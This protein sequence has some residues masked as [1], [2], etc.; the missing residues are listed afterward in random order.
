MS[1]PELK[2]PHV[3]YP[4]SDGK[5]M[6]ES[7]LHRDLLTELVDSVNRHF[8]AEPD[9]Y[10]SGNLL[11]YFEEGNPQMSVAPDFFLVRGVPK[12]RRRIYRLWEEGKGPDVVV[13][14]T[15]R[16]THLEDIGHKR[17]I[18]EEL[19]VEEYFLFD[20]EGEWL[21]PRLKGFRRAGGA[22]QPMEEPRDEGGNLVLPSQVLGF[23][24]LAQGT[25]LRLRD[26]RTLR[27][28]P[29]PREY[30]DLAEAE[31]SRAEAERSRADTAEAE[32][33]RLREEV[34]RS[35]AKKGD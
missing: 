18:Y 10:V 19:G 16:S 4:E 29:T 30:A 17:A 20:P 1:L 6:A 3:H 32:L 15:S 28:L 7:D 9:V 2:K 8:Q 21:R 33:A 31:H 24:L 27:L 23:E 11:I 13:E 26:P 12:K 22:L 5:P 34:A 35:R 14:L 25:S